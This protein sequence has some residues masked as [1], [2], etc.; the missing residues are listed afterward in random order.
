[1]SSDRA[2]VGFSIVA[3]IFALTS[4][5]GVNSALSSVPFWDEWDSY[6]NFYT[7]VKSGDYSAWWSQHNEHRLVISKL[8]FWIDLS[9]FNGSRAFLLVIDF[10]FILFIPVVF[11]YIWLRLGPKS[12]AFV[13]PFFFTW[14]LWWVQEE[15]FTW[16]FQSQLILAQLLPLLAFLA[17][18]KSADSYGTST[19]WFA[20]S[21]LLGILSIGTMANGVLALPLLTIFSIVIGHGRLRVLLLLTLS[22]LGVLLYFHGWAPNPG[23]GSMS[24]AVRDQPMDLVLY[25]LAYLGGPFSFLVGKGPFG[26][27]L[28]QVLGVVLIFGSAVLAFLAL[29]ERSQRKI[30]LALLFFILFVGGS[31][32]GTAGARVIFG[33]DQALSG[34]YQTPLLMAWAA[35]FIVL[36]SFRD[37]YSFEV[38]KAKLVFIL[39]IVVLLMIPVQ[40][41]SLR[42]RTD[43][44]FQHQL[45]GL[46]LELG[47]LDRQQIK[48]V[49]PFP[50]R[51]LEISEKPVQNNWSV[52]GQTWLADARSNL[53]SK[54]SAEVLGEECQVV[55]MTFS[56]IQGDARFVRVTGELSVDSNCKRGKALWVL[57]DNDT[58]VGYALIRSASPIRPFSSKGNGKT[59]RF[60]GYVL[61]PDSKASLS[62]VERSPMVIVP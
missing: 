41:R 5:W 10:F 8:L 37:K 34:R 16:A 24:A 55:N 47:V 36:V 3:L 44:Y 11:S 49:Y 14:F 25:F 57:S 13:I 9:F 40:G 27:A 17:L 58:S 12:F 21:V 38:K 52:F 18:Q 51:A 30:Q 50:K 6:L 46:A 43:H 15:N 56:T 23:H 35:F 45:A 1:M 54:V 26:M 61:T 53:G 22:V 48:K 33:L 20:I 19:R 42:D 4:V 31:G 32:L 28:A 39:A 2:L 62:L 7:T 29:R 59:Q 60:E